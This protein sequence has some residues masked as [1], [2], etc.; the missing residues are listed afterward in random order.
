MAK[1]QHKH[2]CE[3]IPFLQDFA[4]WMGSPEG[5]LS[6][7]VS[8]AVWRRLEKVDVD[9]KRRKLIW[10]DGKALSIT[11]SV[12]RIHAEY[13]DVSVRRATH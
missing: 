10:E 6:G 2:P 5:K 12:Q 1:R 8:D 3:D 7:E 4:D 11:E 13:P 9:A